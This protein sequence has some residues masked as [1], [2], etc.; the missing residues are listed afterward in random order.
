MCVRAV[1]VAARNAVEPAMRTTVC[2]G[3]V[4]AHAN[5]S[6]T[7]PA[8]IEL[9]AF[10]LIALFAFPEKRRW[11]PSTPDAPNADLHRFRVHDAHSS[12]NPQRLYGYICAIFEKR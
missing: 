2:A 6:K 5:K 4:L 9:N 1:R 12:G 7:Q 3:I 10:T 11:R 8:V